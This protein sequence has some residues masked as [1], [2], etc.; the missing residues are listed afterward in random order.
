MTGCCGWRAGGCSPPACR[1]CRRRAGC[2]WRMRIPCRGSGWWRGSGGGAA[3]GSGSRWVE[4]ET[5][6][7]P[8]PGRG[9]GPRV[10]V[11]PAGGRAG[12][13]R[14]AHSVR[15]A[16]RAPARS[17][18]ATPWRGPCG[19]AHR[20]PEGG[21]PG[22]RP[23][24]ARRRPG[25]APTSELDLAGVQPHAHVVGHVLPGIDEGLAQRIHARPED[26]AAVLRTPFAAGRRHGQ[27]VLEMRH[28]P[29]GEQLEAAHGV[30]AVGPFMRAEQHAAGAALGVFQ[31]PLD[32]LDDGLGA[33][34]QRGAG[35]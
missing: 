7:G 18:G 27:R 34:H 11:L 23:H 25:R 35:L 12:D 15:P 28:D 22:W 6:P 4:N 29:T 2:G 30:L 3:P 14:H 33:A 19:R 17:S 5:G 32:A 9:A 10:A 16:M 24:A 21:L 1:R 26:A 8:Q 13:A 31:Q 20:G